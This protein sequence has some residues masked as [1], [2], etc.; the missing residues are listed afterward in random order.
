MK[1]GSSSNLC[2]FPVDAKFDDGSANPLTSK[3]LCKSAKVR[4]NYTNNPFNG[5]LLVPHFFN[6]HA[7]SQH[8]EIIVLSIDKPNFSKMKKNPMQV[9]PKSHEPGQTEL[10]V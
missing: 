9:W 2:A 4:R 8:K 1:G 3:P 7:L 10:K 6:L 5:I